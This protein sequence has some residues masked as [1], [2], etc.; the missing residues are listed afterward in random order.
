MPVS[1]ILTVLVERRTARLKL[2]VGDGRLDFV[3]DSEGFTSYLKNGEPS[4]FTPL[5]A[6]GDRPVMTA[7]EGSDTAL[8]LLSP[9]TK[10]GEL[11]ARRGSLS[12]GFRRKLLIYREGVP[13]CR[14]YQ[15]ASL[16]VLNTHCRCLDIKINLAAITRAKVTLKP[17]EMGSILFR[18]TRQLLAPGGGEL[19]HSPLADWM[20]ARGVVDAQTIEL[21][22][23]VH[24][25]NHPGFRFVLNGDRVNLTQTLPL[26]LSLAGITLGYRFLVRLGYSGTDWFAERHKEYGATSL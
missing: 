4:G 23:L 3:T 5:N 21:A 6:P 25:S 11:T 10:G 22:V 19:V 7:L 18:I 9:S 1:G 26:P 12:V 17:Q 20:A 15:E 8:C 14:Q 13:I 24:G 16:S 2:L